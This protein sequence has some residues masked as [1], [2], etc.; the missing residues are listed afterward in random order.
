MESCCWYTTLWETALSEVMDFF[1]K[2]LISHST[3]DLRSEAWSTRKHTNLC[4]KG[5]FPHCILLQPRWP[6][7]SKFSQICYSMHM[8]GYTKWEYWSWTIA[9]AARERTTPPPGAQSI[10]SIDGRMPTT[11]V[12]L[13]LTSD[14]N[15]KKKK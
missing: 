3:K 10:V 4:N 11:T 6:I 15:K 12:P 9:A 14:K 13:S 2:E 8:L 1:E 5:I 7:E